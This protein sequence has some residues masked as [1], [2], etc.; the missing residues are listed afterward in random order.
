MKGIIAFL[1]VV[2]TALLVNAQAQA[3]PKPTT[4]PSDVKPISKPDSVES[5]LLD[6]KSA[7]A[8]VEIC[9]FNDTNEICKE[10]P[11]K[12]VSEIYQ[13]SSEALRR[14]RRCSE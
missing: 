9:G 3:G 4:S 13:K 6:L 2:T 12:K 10:N 1:I 5:L 11:A 8:Q 14:S 7:E